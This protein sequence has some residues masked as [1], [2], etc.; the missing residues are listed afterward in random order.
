[1]IEK[2]KIKV[3]EKDAIKEI[4]QCSDLKELEALRIKYLGRKSTL[5][6]LLSQLG[7]LP[8]NERPEFGKLLN[9]T[10]NK[11]KAILEKKKQE[12]Q[13][14]S[15]QEKLKGEYVDITMPGKT[16][17]VGARHI[18]FQVMEEIEDIFIGMGFEIAD[19]P[20]IETEYYNFDALNTPEWH[21]ARELSDTFYLKNGKL[22]RTQTSPVQVRVM[23]KYPP[24][25]RI[26]SPGR[27]YRNDKPDASHSPVFHQVEGL[28]VDE[29]VTL[30]DLKGTL[31]SFLKQL[32]GKEV[33]SR[34]RPH[35]FP[36][37][38]PSAEV[39]IQCIRCKGKG[40]VLCKKSGWV[41]IAGAGMV[42]PA[43]LKQVNYDP[44]KFTGFAFGLGIE[45]IVVIRYN[46]PDIRMLFSNDLR[47]LEQF[48]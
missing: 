10:K 4:D 11:I 23:E 22:L 3:I 42:H 18:L 43:V 12:L 20:E 14:K 2:K 40:C 33:Q 9:Q 37:T 46:I 6:K 5:S 17:Q 39:D 13:L 19:G 15:E 26:I 24:P 8:P 32:F 28:V 31:D 27:C 7:T 36:F 45:R 25:I 34:F 35:F 29:N 38:E 44:E 1:M 41:E 30:P 16:V 48:I 21:P 47:F